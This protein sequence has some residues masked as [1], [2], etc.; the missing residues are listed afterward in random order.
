MRSMLQQRRQLAAL[1][2]VLA[3]LS[4][5]CPTSSQIDKAAR[6]S[7]D[8]SRY[9]A[10]AI[11]LTRTLFEQQL[12]SLEKKDQI[13]DRL[14]ELSKAGKS[15]NELITNLNTQYASGTVPPSAWTQLSQNFDQ[16]SALFI[17]LLDAIGAVGQLG[18]SKAMKIVRAAVVTLAAILSSN[19]IH[20][21]GVSNALQLA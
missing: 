4:T 9:T 16:I 15:F 14:L 18:N 17:Q 3:I 8:L 5:A 11:S 6:A 10:D 13:A 21:K 12:I 2:L 7:N 20:T 1:I 19:G